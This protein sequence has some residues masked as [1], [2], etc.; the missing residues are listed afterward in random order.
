MMQL[1]ARPFGSCCCESSLLCL[2]SSTGFVSF[3]L[4]LLTLFL[5]W[6]ICVLNFCIGYEVKVRKRVE[7]VQ[8][9]C[10]DRR[11]YVY[12]KQLRGHAV[13]EDLS[14]SPTCRSKY[15]IIFPDVFRGIYFGWLSSFRC[16]CIYY[17]GSLFQ[18]D[19]IVLC[20]FCFFIFCNIVFFSL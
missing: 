19:C 12:F 16:S 5:S 14:F 20:S 6:T 7:S 10:H 3:P 9:S 1:V 13:A 17:I 8:S 11:Q 18:C 2:S 15:A 4:L